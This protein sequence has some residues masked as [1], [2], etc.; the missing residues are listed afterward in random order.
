MSS[1]F[2]EFE[3]LNYMEPHISKKI[4]EFILQKKGDNSEL[5]S[6][7]ENILKQ[8]GEYDLLVEKGIL[9]QEDINS[10]KEELNKKEEEL[11]EKLHGFLNLCSNCKKSNNYDISSFPLGKKIVSIIILIFHRMMKHL[12]I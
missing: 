1:V 2:P 10:I 5:K 7:Y 3:Y 9:K 8:C 11:K 6:Q 4:I 12:P